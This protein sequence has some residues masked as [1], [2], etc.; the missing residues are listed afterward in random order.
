VSKEYDALKALRDHLL[1]M[2]DAAPQANLATGQI[3]IDYPDTD[4]MK[5][6]VMI[7]IVPDSGSWETL[8]TDSLLEQN[9][10]TVYI[11][12]QN[13]AT[14]R[15][16]STMIEA[17][18][19]YFAAL[20]SAIAHDP[21]LGSK[22]E[23]TKINSF[24]FYPAISNLTKSVGLEVNLTLQFERAGMLLPNDALYPSDTLLPVGG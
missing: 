10:T 11:V 4:V 1:L 16:M 13:S 7:F 9:V 19:D 3:V 8:T 15:E 12:L 23:D 22:I 20:G 6:P 18:F 21:T 2:M 14:H 24:T 17:V 5:Y